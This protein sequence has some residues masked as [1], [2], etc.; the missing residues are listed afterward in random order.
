MDS[1]VLEQLFPVPSLPQS[2]LSPSHFPGVSPESTAKLQSILKDN[3]TRWHIFF[4]EKRFHNHAAHR[5]IAAWA[6][7]AD[8]SALQAGYDKDCGYE[9]KAFESPGPITNTTFN[10]HL[11]DD[12]YFNAYEQFFTQYIKENG[13]SKAIE[14]FIFSR[15]W[16]LGSN[17]LSPDKQPQ[18]LSRF[19]SGVLH[20][21]IHTGYGAE[22][23]IPGMVVEGLAQTAL[24][25][26]SPDLLAPLSLFEDV[27][28][29]VAGRL[30]NRQ[31][32][33]SAGEGIG[34]AFNTAVSALD[35]A[36]DKALHLDGEGEGVTP[37]KRCDVDKAQ[38]EQDNGTKA[39]AEELETTTDDN[40]IH[41]LTILSRVLSDS[42]FAHTE[43]SE[44]SEVNM[45]DD[46]V[47][48]HGKALG[49]YVNQWGI[50]SDTDLQRKMEEVVWVVCVL[51][52][53]GGWTDGKLRR[54]EH[55]FNADFFFMHL[56]TSS[57]FL[58]A[59]CAR[60]SPVSQVRLLK[61][62]F[63]T[64]LTWAIA[65]GQP[66][67][68]VR[69]FVEEMHKHGSVVGPSASSH[70]WEDTW[71]RMV[72]EARAHHDEHVTKIIRAL[73]GWAGDFGTR[74]ARVPIPFHSGDE[75][76]G[77]NSSDDVGMAQ[78]GSAG[79]SRDAFKETSAGERSEADR[80]KEDADLSPRAWRDSKN[81]GDAKELY[82]GSFY[83]SGHPQAHL[84]SNVFPATELE[85]SEYLDGGLFL[86][87]GVLTLGR[88]GWDLDGKKKDG[89]KWE[90]QEGQRLEEEFW[91]LSG[92]VQEI[93]KVKL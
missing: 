66:I 79:R 54:G 53:I 93:P 43:F 74:T 36:L 34:A 47:K 32:A 1:S 85:G 77:S 61:A 59:L 30:L 80:Q 13:V 82:Q 50:S 41:A 44:K 89:K 24:H 16:N 29:R 14:E 39:N 70:R 45:F 37:S 90:K 81:G 6:L 4:N 52:G 46:V 18:M 12:R 75:R 33:A 87:L 9:K 71:M 64:A 23:R 38:P 72:E 31:F 91:D 28:D 65:R 20:P 5:A 3:H 67:L 22:F 49:E 83:R 21:L 19:L 11:G 86:R 48:M 92:M 17:T 78:R 62:Y 10:E 15:R 55:D 58:P 73:S 2:S 35:T 68:N 88:M 40:G 7:G 84:D 56:V 8:A 69:G 63:A 57:I 27:D 60:I 26:S 76:S 25:F 51:Y 42:R